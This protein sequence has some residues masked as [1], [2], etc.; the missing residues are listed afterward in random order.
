MRSYAAIGK[1]VYR[2]GRAARDAAEMS[3][4]AADP[5]SGPARRWVMTAGVG[6][7]ELVAWGTLV[8]AFSALVVPMMRELHWSPAVF[9]TVYTLGS[10]VSGLVS[11]PVGRI[12]ARR[13]PHGVML[14]GALLACAALIGWSRVH[15]LWSFAVA[16]GAVGVAM[17][18]T[19]YEPAFALTAHWFD[20]TSRPKAVAVITMLAGLAGT[21]FVPLLGWLCAAVG[22][23][24]ALLVLAGI[25]VLVSAPVHLILLRLDRTVRPGRGEAAP[26]AQ[27]D[28]PSATR[29]A[30][31]RWMV[32]CL[33]SSTATK[34]TMVVLLVAFLVGL[35]QPVGT[36]T[37]LAGLV[38]LLQV[39]GR[40]GTAALS[41]RM[42]EERTSVVLFGVQA[43]ALLA[44]IALPGP[45]LWGTVM[46]AVTVAGFGLGA[47]QSELMRGTLLV[48]LYGPQR[49]PRLNGV[50]SAFV[51]AARGCGPFLAGLLVTA[52][53]SYAPALALAGG[54]AVVAAVS[55]PVAL[56]RHRQETAR[57]AG[58]PA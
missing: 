45:G 4:S 56:R 30:S 19:L 13:S 55:L 10:V 50:V 41:S 39:V 22:W 25:C 35:G 33:A 7:T 11:V 15:S 53:G 40:F 57:R 20:R 38:G 12:L 24:T 37:L 58:R 32:L 46:A 28:E 23:R 5:D 2:A 51:V 31:F 27:G 16:F 44:M 47:G 8:Y 52:T 17:A 1:L 36:A 14:A 21:V 9:T 34:Y 29:R 18:M 54:L 43:V 42:R 49:Y 48:S 3:P 26:A 6:V